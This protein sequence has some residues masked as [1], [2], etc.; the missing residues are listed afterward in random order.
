MRLSRRCHFA[1]LIIELAAVGGCALAPRTVPVDPNVNLAA[2]SEMLF[3]QGERA[4]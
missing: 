3:R 4:L 1:W 2:H